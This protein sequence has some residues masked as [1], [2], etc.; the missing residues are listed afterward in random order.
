[1]NISE[2]QDELLRSEY[3]YLL[4]DH[5]PDIERYYYLRSTGQPE[6]ALRIFQSR[7]KVRYPND[8]F[9]TAL[10]R[11]YRSRDPAFRLLMSSAYRTL[12]EHSL[13]RV[14]RAINY[15]TEKAD[16][17]NRRDVYSTI[18]AAEDIMKLLPPDRFE[19]VAGIER[20]LRYAQAMD[21]KVKSMVKAVE[22]I[23]AYLTQSLSVAE[24]EKR[25]RERRRLR[26]EEANRRTMLRFGGPVIDFSSVVFSS[27]D[28]FRIE[29]P[30]NITRIEDQILAFCVKYWNLVDDSAFERILF[31]YS[32]KYGTKHYDVFL[33]IRRSRMAK[34]RDDEI[35]SAVMSAL[36]SGY[37]YSIR[38]DRYLQIRWNIIKAQMNSPDA[39][40]A[41]S[42]PGS[43]SAKT[44]EG[45][46]TAE[47]AG[48]GDSR[49]P[50]NAESEAPARRS[51]R[52]GTP[53]PSGGRKPPRKRK[54]ARK[55]A[56]KRPAAIR[57]EKAPAAKRPA[58][59][60]RDREIREIPARRRHK[61]RAVP[62]PA[63]GSVSDRL[64]ELSGRSYDLYRERFLSHVRPSIRKTLA[65]GRG[66]F[67]N[68]PEKAEN[69][70]FSFLNEHYS[71]PYMNWAESGER[72]TLEEMGFDIPSLYPVIDECYH[73]L[74]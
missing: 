4:P 71:D 44:A 21:F 52:A 29:I 56:G 61:F 54:P 9:R 16:H 59:T 35:L 19:A 34:R 22:L 18:R 11:S 49:K 32:R 67:F 70:V 62:F 41:L 47:S 65:A 33:A 53:A 31:L 27:A 57:P 51:A 40:F 25:R 17:Y 37:Y 50:E 72:K 48:T 6:D 5:D 66:I 68:P 2:I 26:E 23:R 24:N 8:E 30:G 15:I 38:G 13:E 63:S 7:L 1:M 45:P 46:K 60:G 10:L 55:K 74:A 43:G 20:F 12:G 69:L 28:L 14:R 64:Q 42:V 39:F 58:E 36:V 3:P 73:G